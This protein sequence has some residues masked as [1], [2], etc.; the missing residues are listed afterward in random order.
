MKTVLTL[1]L[2]A[3]GPSDRAELSALIRGAASSLGVS[4]AR[5]D[6]LGLPA[7]STSPSLAGTPHAAR[8]IRQAIFEDNPPAPPR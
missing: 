5:L 8:P 4:A 7:A 3:L 2:L 1:I 6:A